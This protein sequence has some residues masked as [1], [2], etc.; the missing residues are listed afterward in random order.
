[1]LGVGDGRL[2]IGEKLAHELDVWLHDLDFL[3]KTFL[4][5]QELDAFLVIVLHTNDAGQRV[6]FALLP[7]THKVLGTVMVNRAFLQL[8]HDY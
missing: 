7:Q 2:Y 5:H 4:L 1:M 6:E 3:L 8:I